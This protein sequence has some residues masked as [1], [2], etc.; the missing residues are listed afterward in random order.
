MG[1]EQA[2]CSSDTLGLLAGE[3]GECEQ[4]LQFFPA[5]PPP[6]QP[7]CSLSVATSGTPINQNYGNKCTY[8]VSLHAM[9]RNGKFRSM[10]R[11]K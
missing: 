9:N 5:L 11:S 4:Q 1:A 3:T 7:S 2:Y 8:K 6:P 10:G